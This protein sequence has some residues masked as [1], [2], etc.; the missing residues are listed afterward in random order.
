MSNK[1]AALRLSVFCVAFVGTAF[2]VPFVSHLLV[3]GALV[4]SLIF[5]H[6]LGHYIWFKRAGI[7]IQAFSLGMGPAVAVFTRK[8]GEKWIV[9]LLPV[10]GYVQPQGGE[11]IAKGDVVNSG[12]YF[13]AYPAGRLKGILAGPL[14]NI[15]FGLALL[16]AILM[17]P[18]AEYGTKI[19]QVADNS[20]AQ[21]AGVVVGDRIA[22]VNGAKVHTRS[23]LISNLQQLTNQDTP[24]V[25]TFESANGVRDKV[26]DSSFGESL[27][28]EFSQ[29]PVGYTSRFSP[30][31]AVGKSVQ[32]SVGLTIA[33]ATSLANITSNVENVSGP[34]NIGSMVSTR[35][36]EGG[37]KEVL[38]IIA[39]ISIVLGVF[40]LIP[41]LPLDGGH[42]VSTLAEMAGM[43]IP[44]GVQKAVTLVVAV[45]LFALTV[46]WL[47]WDVIEAVLL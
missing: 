28:I 9:A 21:A 5:I 23:A 18:V 14:V 41:L 6:E 26:V 7:V 33:T 39:F 29:T 34:A 45:P 25:L 13:S 2:F 11:M 36:R 42:V 17:W 44:A 31:Q 30:L 20:P 22:A 4:G 16:S 10:G 12:D 43:P 19:S 35:N 27:G 32:I 15:L 1:T 46:V 40:N 3:F 37:L 8:N 38:F 47:L 24:V